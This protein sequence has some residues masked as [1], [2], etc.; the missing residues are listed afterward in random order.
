MTTAAAA[1]SGLRRPGRLLPLL[2]VAAVVAAVLALALGGVPIPPGDILAV[3]AGWV[4]LDPATAID[5]QSQLVLEAIRGPRVLLGCIVGA[6]LAVGGAVMQ[7]LFRNPL[8]DPGLVGVSA[9]AAMAVAAAIVVGDVMSLGGLI[10]RAYVLPA[11]AFTGGLAATLVVYGLARADGRTSVAIMLLAGIAINAVAGAITGLFTYLSDDQ[12]LRQLTMW[13]MGSLSGMVPGALLPAVVVMVVATAGCL[14]LWR[15]LDLMLLGEAEAHHLGVRVELLKRTAVVL[16]ALGV[17]AAVS[18]AGP[19][20]FVGLV[21]P[22]LV[23][24][25]G[26]AGHRLVLPGAALLGMVMTCLSDLVARMVVLPGELPVGLV[27][28]AGGGPFFLA[29]LLGARRRGELV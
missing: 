29:L 25:I 12:Q 5:P 21:A 9:G 19:I 27:L 8:A 18:A 1:G 4:G 14:M 10:P 23:R 13:G 3:M 15:P 20:A 7:A 16:V 2:A 6:T 17:G 24:L 26:G 22:H 11:A 28:A